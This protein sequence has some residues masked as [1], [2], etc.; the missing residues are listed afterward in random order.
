MVDEMTI[1]ENDLDY[2]TYIALRKAVGWKN[3]CREQVEQ[4]ITQSYYSVVIRENGESIAMGRIIGD[5]LYFTIVDVVVRPD[6]RGKGLGTLIIK[7]LI[8]HIEQGVPAGGRV[9]IQLIS[10]MGKEDFYVK[11]GFKLIPH[12]NCGPA[13]RKIIC[14]V[15]NTE[16]VE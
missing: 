1:I 5:G 8:E 6:Y 11:Q 10:E 4:A 7:K 12:E 9:S 13:L 16:E 2:E 3:F 14:K 15:K